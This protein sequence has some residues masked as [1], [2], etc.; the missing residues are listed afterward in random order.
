MSELFASLTISHV[1]TIIG[2]IVTLV[3]AYH[4]LKNKATNNSTEI[5][6][7]KTRMDK[8]DTAMSNSE[9]AA[10]KRD[11]M[12]VSH[13]HKIEVLERHSNKFDQTL[14]AVNNTLTELNTTIAG[15]SATVK[16][17]QKQ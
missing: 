12:L 10:N 4:L 16:A 1:A 14:E 2:G 17:M 13:A 5:V 11:I 7:I 9:T 6:N 15:L 3:G 8:F